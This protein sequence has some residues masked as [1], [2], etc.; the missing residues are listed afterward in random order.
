MAEPID[1]FA[2]AE[3]M[4]QRSQG[5]IPADQP[6]LEEELK[7]ATQLIR[8]YCGWHIA[9]VQTDTINI[10]GYFG[11]FIFLPTLRVVS[12][13]ELTVNGQIIDLVTDPTRWEW[14][15]DGLQT[16][17]WENRYQTG[18]VT[19]THGFDEVPA[20]LVTLTLM[21]A[22]RA[23]GSPL[24]V[25]RESTMSSSITYSQSGFNQA[26]GTTLLQSEKDGLQAYK[27]GYTP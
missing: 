6:F 10:T 2:S 11:R 1:T 9:T 16:P 15:K 24:G 3:Q 4:A 8:N 27:I 21:V 18:E 13:D 25:V 14:V 19:I 20:D 7:A 23:L 17:V 5:A 22:S 26:G 12:I